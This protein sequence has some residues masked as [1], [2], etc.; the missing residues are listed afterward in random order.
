MELSGLA[1]WRHAFSSHRA[2]T[3]ASQPAQQRAHASC[4]QILDALRSDHALYACV[5]L[6][7]LEC[8]TAHFGAVFAAQ[9]LVVAISVFVVRCMLCRGVATV[10]SQQERSSGGWGWAWCVCYDDRLQ[11]AQRCTGG[12]EYRSCEMLS[13]FCER[14]VPGQGSSLNA[15]VCSLAFSCS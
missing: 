2:R 6:A 7:Q 10:T 5:H 15:I 11:A 9:G 3:H 8:I 12:S 4:M 13:R 14:A 1:G